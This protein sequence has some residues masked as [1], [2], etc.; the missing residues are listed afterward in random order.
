MKEMNVFPVNYCA[1]TYNEW[2]VMD[3]KFQL[4]H[5]KNSR[6]TTNKKRILKKEWKMANLLYLKK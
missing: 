6:A 4:Y 1:L 3:H 2:N 5:G